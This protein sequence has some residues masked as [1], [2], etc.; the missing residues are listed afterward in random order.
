[1][2]AADW[3]A[4]IT[5]ASGAIGGIVA[6]IVAYRRSVNSAKKSDLD[7]AF[8]LIDELQDELKTERAYRVAQEER[9]T[10]ERDEWRRRERQLLQRIE[11]L[12]AKVMPG[13][14]RNSGPLGE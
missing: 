4:I 1:M 11:E 13:R 12:E 8:K 2:N 3:V 14:V 9:H 6:A 7:R 10:R 5:G